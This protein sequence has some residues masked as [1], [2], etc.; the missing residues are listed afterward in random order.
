MEILRNIS[1]K[2]NSTYKIGGKAVFFCVAE[3]LNDVIEAIKYAKDNHLDILPI[4]GASNILFSDSGYTGLVLKMANKGINIIKDKENVVLQVNAGVN[5][6]E[7]I[8]FAS[9]NN[10]TGLEW[11]VGI[12]GTIGGAIANNAGIKEGLSM[13]DCIIDVSV[14]DTRNLSQKDFLKQDCNF[15]YRSSIFKGNNDYVIMG[16][17]I[18]LERSEKELIKNKEKEILE[19]RLQTQPYNFPSVGS[20]FKNPEN[21]SAGKLI[22]DCGLKGKQI[23]GAQISLMHG[24]FIINVGN[25][26]EK[27]VKG[28]I[29]LIKEAV[30]N[31]FN[32]LLEEEIEFF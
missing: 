14:V 12:P 18:V 23:G 1:L 17:K 30:K 9:D 15:L 32:I 20:V 6:S 16:A 21:Y 7:L 11:G 8:S 27:D 24:N 2:D 3:G 13:G 25:A 10:L 5:L 29:K 31:K 26:T 19:K 28:L 4:G 22:E